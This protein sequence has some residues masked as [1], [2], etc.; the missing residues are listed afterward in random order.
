MLT[1]SHSYET[2]PVFLLSSTNNMEKVLVRRQ[3]QKMGR[4]RAGMRMGL[5]WVFPFLV[6]VCFFKIVFNRFS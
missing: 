4:G 5:G 3:E 1:C 6:G 2:L